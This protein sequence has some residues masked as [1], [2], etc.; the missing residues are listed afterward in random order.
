MRSPTPNGPPTQPVLTSQQAASCS[1]QLFAQQRRVGRR[2]PRQK[3]RAEA[4]AEGGLRLLAQAALGARNLGRVAA[5]KVI[6]GLLRRQLRDRRQHAESVGG[7]E[8]HVARM[9]AHAGN[10]GVLDEIERIRRARVFGNRLG[11]EIELRESRVHGHVFQHGAEADGVPDL[12]LLFLGEPDALGIAAAF[13]IEDAA[14]RSSRARRRRSGG[15]GGS[16]ERVV[17]PVPDSPKKSATSP[18]APTF[19]EQCMGNIPRSGSR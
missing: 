13:E 14:G 10:Q 6:H 12:R 2:G 8:N 16:A 17:L 11:I 15:A 3:R 5:Q 4:G 18:A 19:A 1:P 7:Q 9:P